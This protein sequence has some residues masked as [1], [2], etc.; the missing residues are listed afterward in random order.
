MLDFVGHHRKEFR[1]DLRYRALLGRSRRQL[2]SDIK[3]GF[4]YLP[5]GCLLELDEVSRKSVLK[6]TRDSLPTDWRHRIDEL[7]VLGDTTLTNYLHETGLELDD[8]YRGKHTWTELRRAAGVDNTEASEGEA[9]VGRGIARLLHLDDEDRI[10]TYRDLLSS[11]NPPLASTL[12]ERTRRQ[13]EGLLLTVL[14][15]KKNQYRDLEQAAADL[16]RHD[17]LRNEL[18]EILGLFDE[19]ILHL[20]Q[21][22]G[23][24]QP[25]PLQ[26]H[27]SY[28]RE[29]IL[30]AFG[31]STVSKPMPLQSGVYWHDPTKTDL[32]FVTLQK[33]EKEYSPTTRYLDNAISE[34]LFH[35]ESQ[36]K[37]TVASIRGQNYL[38]HEQRDRSIA[39]FIRSAKKEPNGRTMAY[40]CAGTATYV[41]H[42]SERPI[43]ITW[44]LRYALPGDVFADYRAA[45]A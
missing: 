18:V 44:K 21:P 30:A 6:N 34:H 13:L 16:W 40:F 9:M 25:V 14:N 20:H 19:Q 7:R 41:E 2:E 24:L 45:V 43:Q 4:P 10:T 11:P 28:T 31:A 32:L 38:H 35:W 29:D 39:L 17:G 22:I 37:D 36:A 3:Q 5:A 26:V 12:D 15:P 33:T 42:Q 27:A 23:L 8:I 1:F